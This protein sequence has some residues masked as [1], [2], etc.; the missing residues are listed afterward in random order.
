MIPV[1]TIDGPSGAGKGTVS[2]AIA[3]QLG[4][5]YLDSG[6]IYRAVGIACL[7]QKVDFKQIDA[8]IKIAKNIQISFECTTKL[9]VMLNGIDI[10]TELNFETTA[11]AASVIAA[12][13]EIRTVLQQK[14]KAFQQSPG[15]VADGRDMGTVVFLDAQHK[16]YLTAGV[17]IRAKRRYKQ[18]IEKGIDANL[19]KII[20]AIEI[21]DKRDSERTIAPLFPANDALYLDASDLSIAQVIE[22]ILNFIQ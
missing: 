7:Q 12:I 11:N 4:W 1:L 15:L 14:L 9:V 16:I 13:P 3:Q 17:E 5:H 6:A 20:K 19:V 22:K 2:R 8:V 10:T 21:R 18:L